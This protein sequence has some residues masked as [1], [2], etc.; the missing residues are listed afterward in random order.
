LYIELT[1]A[2]DQAVSYVTQLLLRSFCYAA[3]VTQLLLRSFCYA[4]SVT[5]LLL[6]SF[7]YSGTNT[8]RGRACFQGRHN[9]AATSWWL[10]PELI[11][12]CTEVL[13]YGMQMRA[14][15]HRSQGYLWPSCQAQRFAM[16]CKACMQLADAACPGTV[17]VQLHTQKCF[18]AIS[19]V[20]G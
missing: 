11:M 10:A 9:K 13:W 15:A 7:C 1:M 3:S 17:G 18:A 6:R 2:S 8:A 20:A 16:C 5:Q 12:W 4:A 19:I 14:R